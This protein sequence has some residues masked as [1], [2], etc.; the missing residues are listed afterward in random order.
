M[1]VGCPALTRPFASS[2]LSESLYS[3]VECVGSSVGALT[4]MTISLQFI[5]SDRLARNCCNHGLLVRVAWLQYESPRYV[6]GEECQA[7]ELQHSGNRKNM[8]RP[9]HIV[10]VGQHFAR[11]AQPAADAS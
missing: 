7:T 8:P 1:Q 11:D 10:L 5:P 2:S 4:S 3:C 6:D 9:S